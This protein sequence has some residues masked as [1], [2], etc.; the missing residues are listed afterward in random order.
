MSGCSFGPVADLVDLGKLD[1]PIAQ[2]NGESRGI[3]PLIH[4]PDLLLKVYK[5]HL[6]TAANASRLDWLISLATTAPA[7]DRTR[8]LAN[9][10][11]PL[12]R[13]TDGPRPAHGVL[14]PRAPDKYLTT[15][16]INSTTKQIPLEVDW[17]ASAEDKC[18]RRGIA[19]PTFGER[20]RI[21]EDIVAVADF[22]E[23]H[24]VVYGDWS[25]ANA[26]WC[27]TDSSA[28]VIDLDGCGFRSRTAVA[29]QNWTDDLPNPAGVTDNLTDRF[30]VALLLAR[31]LT[32]VR[33]ID[34]ALAMLRKLAAV[35]HAGQVFTTV[36][37]AVKAPTR[38]QRPA[39]GKML[40][41]MRH[42]GSG[43]APTAP[44]RPVSG[45]VGW[46]PLPA[47]P[48]TATRRP[49]T[50]APLRPPA[51]TRPYTPPPRARPPASRAPAETGGP[52]AAA[53]VWVLVLVALLVVLFVLIS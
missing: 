1:E 20:L 7:V 48:V 52:S 35:H 27:A 14:I 12:S 39:V 17:L 19:V 37:A 33:D 28:Y 10:C 4:C 2:E 47:Q 53:V 41:A 49:P 13:V 36:Y 9:S 46:R 8:L 40:A 32:G 50:T 42:R 15:L 5:D 25:Y 22:L 38:E 51:P 3:Y 44:A 6:S 45:V 16:R 34:A 18:R 31:C 24:E 29:T 30:G 21:C 11:W 26:F 43:A 23:R